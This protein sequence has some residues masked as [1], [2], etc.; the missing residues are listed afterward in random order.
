M[1]N[2]H[3]DRTE[4]VKLRGLTELKMILEDTL[5]RAM[6]RLSDTDP[7]FDAK[8][9]ESME[10]MKPIVLRVSVLDHYWEVSSLVTDIRQFAS[11]ARSELHFHAHRAKRTGERKIVEVDWIG[12][13]RE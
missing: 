3:D 10:G 12:E 11:S 5:L 8:L 7:D 1:S 9:V 2:E 4:R 6:R 13:W